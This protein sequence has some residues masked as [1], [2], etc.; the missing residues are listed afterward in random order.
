MTTEK[1][2]R[3][4]DA[5]YQA[6]RIRE[7]LPALPN[8]VAPSYIHYL[9]VILALE[10]KEVQVK[11][12]DISDK[13]NLPRPGVTRTVKVIIPAMKEMEEK[14]YIKKTVSPEDGRIIYLSATEKGKKLSEKYNEKYFNEL[15]LYLEHI[16]EEE[17][18]GMIQTIE[19]FYQVMCE[20]KEASD[21]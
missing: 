5:C 4:L 17:A 10:K 3:M 19:K 20:R 16:S 8:G 1:I 13:L 15:A 21:K 7:L 18:D 2:K 11:I 6:K 14:G 9:D 12:S